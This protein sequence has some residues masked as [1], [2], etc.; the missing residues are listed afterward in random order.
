MQ[1]FKS[2]LPNM[3]I[4]PRI[5]NY[6]LEENEWGRG[7]KN[8]VY[9]MYAYLETCAWI[10]CVWIWPWQSRSGKLSTVRASPS[11]R[12]I[13]TLYNMYSV[14]HKSPAMHIK[15]LYRWH[16]VTL[17]T[18]LSLADQTEADREYRQTEALWINLMTWKAAVINTDYQHDLSGPC[19]RFIGSE[20]AS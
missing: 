4:N 9:R 10:S 7:L 5:L 1:C 3:A 6:G 12:P 13:D 8:A 2:A 19:V 16:S 20:N 18:I 14:I 17:V 11:E 15:L